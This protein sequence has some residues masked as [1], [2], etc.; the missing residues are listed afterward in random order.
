MESGLRK[1]LQKISSP[2]D[3]IFRHQL[4]V[5][6]VCLAISVFIW[7]LIVL[8]KESYTTVNYPIIYKNIPNRMV[9]VNHPDSFLTFRIASEGFELFTL[10]YLTRKK[11]V[12]IDLSRL[13]LRKEGSLF[14][15][16]FPTTEISGSIIQKLNLSE[17]LID[18]TPGNIYFRFEPL[19][20]KKVKVVP[21]LE[22]NF[23]KQF[24]LSDSASVHPDCV[25]VV[26]PK[27]IVGNISFIKTEKTVVRNIEGKTTLRAKL[28][29]PKMEQQVK[30]IP[31]EVEI[32]IPV[33][34]YTEAVIDVPV[35]GRTIDNL[36]MK[37]F[38]EMVKVTYTVSLSDY[39]RVNND[40]FIASV[41]YDPDSTKAQLPVYLS[42]KP[43]F[44]NVIRIEPE[45]VEYIVLKQ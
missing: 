22:L 43:S 27:N 20:G 10:K 16:T 9:L 42:R 32:I 29:N 39:E 13:N 24:Q 35:S 18:I 25:N 4:Y 33:E 8:S 26:G 2:G 19:T 1:L 12:E 45:M 14:V 5:F 6:L 23:K 21:D 3:E 30:L 37:T 11:P 15:S 34:K 28:I 7:F 31:E 38:P 36:K 41:H 44:I 40:M 17:E